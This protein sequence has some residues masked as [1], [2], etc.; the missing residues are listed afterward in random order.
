M[1]KQQRSICA[2]CGITEQ[3][4]IVGI[5]N[6]NKER[7][8]REVFNIQKGI[9]ALTDKYGHGVCVKPGRFGTLDFMIDNLVGYAKFGTTYSDSQDVARFWDIS[10]VPS[11]ML[12]LFKGEYIW[13]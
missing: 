4:E 8:V 12:K 10:K 6:D 1:P 9:Q 3:T 2:K 7:E 13:L 11:H 5:S